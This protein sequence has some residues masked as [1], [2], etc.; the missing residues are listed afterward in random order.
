MVL[1]GSTCCRNDVHA[2]L[3]HTPEAQHALDDWYEFTL[4]NGDVEATIPKDMFCIKQCFCI[5][6]IEK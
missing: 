1:H 5:T 2:W 3:G 6:V 4:Q